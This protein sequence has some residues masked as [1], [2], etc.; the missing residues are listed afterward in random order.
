MAKSLGGL[1][2]GLAWEAVHG[3]AEPKALGV[4]AAKKQQIRASWP[5]LGAFA[6]YYRKTGAQES[7]SWFEAE[8]I[9][10]EIYF[11]GWKSQPRL[12]LQL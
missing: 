6:R 8:T 11:Q 9:E 12:D 4:V 1:L 10:I 2:A 5:L 7:S 3:A